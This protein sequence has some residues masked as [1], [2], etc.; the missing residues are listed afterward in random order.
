MLRSLGI[1]AVI[2]ILGT[3]AGVILAR[4]LGWLR[5]PG[6]LIARPEQ[7]DRPPGDRA[8]GAIVMLVV[9]A[10]PLLL[11]GAWLARS[12][13][14]FLAGNPGLPVWPL[15]LTGWYLAAAPTLFLTATARD[16]AA[17]KLQ[18]GVAAWL[19]PLALAA[20][21]AFVLWP[22]LGDPWIT[23]LPNWPL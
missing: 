22:A 10:V 4:I 9:Q 13:R 6:I 5:L 8:A 19:L 21:W 18:R 2:A 23:W 17:R 1:A 16:E 14:M 20:Y 7:T 3:V 11:Y 12:L 15:L